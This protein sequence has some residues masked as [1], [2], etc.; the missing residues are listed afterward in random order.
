MPRTSGT[1]A[2][3]MSALIDLPRRRAL[4][5]GSRQL[6]DQILKDIGVNRA[7]LFDT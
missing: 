5:D 4:L 3:L 6:D 7:D 2:G 1:L